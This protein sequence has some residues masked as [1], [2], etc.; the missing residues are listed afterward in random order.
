MG[1]RRIASGMF[2]GDFLDFHSAGGAGHE[3]GRAGRAV[4]QNAQVK[5]AL[6]VEAFFDQQAV[7][8]AAFFARLRRDQLHA[9]DVLGERRRLRRPICASFTPPALPRPPA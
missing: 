8:D 9:Q 6:D 3:N 5:L 7:H 4:D 2:F 1:S